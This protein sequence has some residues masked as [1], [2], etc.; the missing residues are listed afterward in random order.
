M[1][2]QSKFDLIIFDLDGTL[3]DGREAI[4]ENFH[5]ALKKFDLPQ[6]EDEEI[7]AMIGLPLVEM[8]ERTL[9]PSNRH[10]APKLVSVYAEK[11]IETGHVGTTILSDVIPTL[12]RLR[13]DGFKL[14]VATSKKNDPVRPLLE[15]LGL[16]KY[17]D[18]VTGCREGMRN[19]PHPDMIRFIKGTERGA[20]ANCNGWR[21]AC[22]HSHSQ[23][24][25]DQCDS[26]DQQRKPRRNDHQQ[27]P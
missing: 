8:F 1:R 21:Y 2:R 17:F 5:F 22:R 13:K 6:V 18:L 4:R 27:D 12:Q 19:K 7:D 10:M 23:K 24:Y 3:V 26:C 25:W 16:H 14:A 20:A 15:R 9:A 11:Y